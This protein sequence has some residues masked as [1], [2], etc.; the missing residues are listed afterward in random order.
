MLLKVL[1]NLQRIEP[2]RGGNEGNLGPIKDYKSDGIDHD[3]RTC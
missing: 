3:H 2:E 1:N